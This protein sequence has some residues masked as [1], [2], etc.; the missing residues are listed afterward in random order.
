MHRSHSGRVGGPEEPVEQSRREFESHPVYMQYLTTSELSSLLCIEDLTLKTGHVIQLL[1]ERIEK[2]L[3]KKYNVNIEACNDSRLVEKIYN[4]DRLYYPT[5]DVTLN[6]KYTKWLN[7]SQML[8]SHTSCMIPK[9][10]DNLKS[11]DQIILA[12][13][14]VYRRDC[15]DK[16]HCSEPHQ[17]DIWRVSKTIKHSRET[18]LDLIGTVIETLMPGSEWRYKETSH[19]YTINGIEVEVNYNN[20]WLEILEAGEINPKLLEDANLEGYTGL[21]M[22]MGLDRIAMVLKQIDDIRVLRNDNQKIQKQMYDLE[23]YRNVSKW[24]SKRRD[25]S[26]CVPVDWDD[27]LLGDNI[28]NLQINEIEEIKIKQAW[29]YDEL[30]K[31]IVEKIG[32]SPALKNVL[33]SIVLSSHVVELSK[34]DAN[35]IYQ[36][37]YNHLDLGK[38]LYL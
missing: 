4:Y 34:Q 38:K 29:S 32:L 31:E 9:K 35:E 22:G 28:R 25:L 7:E 19:Y 27:D 12:Y 30:S 5:D 24:L 11:E 20:Q 37:I 36:K 33:L 14:M 18:L 21:A 23:K 1:V 15:I 8:R 13:G 17:L 26:V 3:F 2:E 16:T 6:S 10:L